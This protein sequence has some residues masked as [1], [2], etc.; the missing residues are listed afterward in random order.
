LH[1]TSWKLGQ[2]SFWLNKSYLS[3]GAVW[4]VSQSLPCALTSVN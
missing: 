4:F 1:K 3:E 2:K